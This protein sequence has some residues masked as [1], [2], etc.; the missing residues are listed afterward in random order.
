[1]RT[2]LHF[3]TFEEVLSTLPTLGFDVQGVPGVAN[4]VLVRKYGAGAILI[5]AAEP[6]QADKKVPHMGEIGRAHV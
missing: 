4:Q 1:M 2:K 3:L 6:E 5:R